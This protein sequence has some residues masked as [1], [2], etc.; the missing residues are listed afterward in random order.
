MHLG[1]LRL[2]NL[3][4]FLLLLEAATGI[5]LM[6]HYRP[7]VG[8]AYSDLVDLREVS[9][10]GF[11]RGLHRWG[12]YAAV[13][14]V[15]LHLLRV[16]V[17]GTFAPPRR[18]NWTIGVA[19][20]L[21]TLLLAATGYL[22]PWDQQAYWG[23]VTLSPAGDSE[24]NSSTLL[25]FYAGHCVALP[26]LVAALTLYHLRRARRDDDTARAN[27]ASRDGEAPEG[28]APPEA[29]KREAAPVA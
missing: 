21:L 16:A 4:V 25:R 24:F 19:L 7:V 13:I 9:G 2:G 6:F 12:A 10:F 20:L 22:L 8:L 29:R 23:V 15:W 5:G 26:L 11:A 17:R 1:N 27:S 18:L 3:A 28:Q 14:V